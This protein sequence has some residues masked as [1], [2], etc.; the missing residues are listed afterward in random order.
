MVDEVGEQLAVERRTTVPSGTSTTRSAPPL[1]CSFLPVPCVPDAG[2]AVRM[3]AE[4]EQRRD[5][6]V[7][8]Q[9]D[10]AAPAAVAAVGTALRH[11]RLAPERDAARAAVATLHVALRGIDEAGHP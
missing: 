4:R 5:V 10:V 1:P 8:A 11:V 9:P 3:I 6:A 2:L 7:R